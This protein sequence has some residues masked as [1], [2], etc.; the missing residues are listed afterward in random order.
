MSGI[1]TRDLSG[2]IHTCWLAVRPG[3]PAYQTDPPEVEVVGTAEAPLA[4]VTQ[5]Q[6]R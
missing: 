2:L 4:S 6:N 3:R 1:Q 5:M